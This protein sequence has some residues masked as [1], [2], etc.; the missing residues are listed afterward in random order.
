MEY[1]PDYDS[2]SDEEIESITSQEHQ[3]KRKTK[4]NHNW[5]RDRTFSSKA[6]ALSD[7]EKGGQSSFHYT[8][9]TSEGTKDYYRCNQVKLRGEQ[10]DAALHLLYDATSEDVIMFKT[11]NDHTHNLNNLRKG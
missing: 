5:I 9:K 4:R 2:D 8:N 1:V 11:D 3:K 6:E 10:C 7:I